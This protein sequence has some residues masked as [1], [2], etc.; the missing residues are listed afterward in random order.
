[1]AFKVAHISDIHVAR[2]PEK[3][4]E[5]DVQYLRSYLERVMPIADAFGGVFARYARQKIEE[6]DFQRNYIKILEQLRGVGEK[7]DTKALIGLS[8]GLFGASMG[9]A[10]IYR[11]ELMKL[12]SS[13]QYRERRE[14]RD[15]LLSSLGEERP[16]V[17]LV[18]GDLTTVASE[19]EFQEAKAFLDNIKNLECRPVVIVIPGN[20]DVEDAKKGEKHARLDTYA[21]V[22]SEYLPRAVAPLKADFGDVVVFG[23]NSNTVGRGLGTDGRVGSR[24]I[25]FLKKE[26]MAVRGRDKLLAIHHH[27]AKYGREPRV[28]PLENAGELLEVAAGGGVKLI[29]H[30]HKHEF[31][32]W[33][34]SGDGKPAEDS[35]DVITVACAG[36]S[37]ETTTWK[38]KKLQYRIFEFDN[39]K[40]LDGAGKIVTKDVEY[41]RIKK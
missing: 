27:L 26:L 10:F 5:A 7:L 36:T 15:I 12:L 18:T 23:V 41:E 38:P 4:A 39:G 3:S 34:Y 19:G 6:K 22:F 32:E 24:T 40:L 9:L 13:L 20:H 30:G 16:D 25:E 33:R 37:T 8:V 17:V 2:Q 35:R 1:M 11:R 14:M 28:P 21:K 29:C 31:Y